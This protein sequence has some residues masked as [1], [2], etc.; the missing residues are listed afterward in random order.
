MIQGFALLQDLFPAVPI[1][2][3]DVSLFLFD[4]SHSNLDARRWLE[5][6]FA[7]LI[8]RYLPC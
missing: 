7:K 5:M 1:S 3:A 4:S 2:D 6:N 8:I